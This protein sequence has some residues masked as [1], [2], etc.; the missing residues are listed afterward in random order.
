M[1]SLLLETSKDGDHTASL[2]NLLHCLTVLMVRK[3]FQISNLSLS[4]SR[5]T[6]VT[7]PPVLHCCK[8]ADSVFSITT[9]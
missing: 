3:S 5:F 1:S 2:G 7:H 9:L 8:E 6:V 4:L